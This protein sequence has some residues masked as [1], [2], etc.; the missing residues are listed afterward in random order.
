MLPLQTRNK[1]NANLL[2]GK[3]R[4]IELFFV[5]IFKYIYY[6][7]YIYVKDI[8]KKIENGKS[9]HDIYIILSCHC[10]C[11]FLRFKI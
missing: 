8:K 2:N 11:L 1:E 3:V 5:F 4:P 6:V 9:Y 10:I 7:I